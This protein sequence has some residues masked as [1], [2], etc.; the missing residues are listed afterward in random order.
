MSHIYDL[1]TLYDLKVLVH[2]IHI[3]QIVQG[4]IISFSLSIS[5]LGILRFKMNVHILILYYI[6]A[7][8]FNSNKKFLRYLSEIEFGQVLKSL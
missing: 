1:Y 6:I 2:L 4:H 3:V 5:K 8:A 7:C